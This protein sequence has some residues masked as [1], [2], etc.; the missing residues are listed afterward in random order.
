MYQAL[1][2]V[3]V[4]TAIV[5]LGANITYIIWLTRVN[6]SPESLIFTLRTIKILDDWVANPA[7]VLS[8]LTGLG[9][10]FV[11]GWSLTTPWLL[12]ASILYILV[13]I[14]GL[15]GY[16]RTLNQQIAVVE[17]G[18]AFSVDY[19]AL[20]RRGQVLGLIIIALVVIIV[21]LMVIKPPLWG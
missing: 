11:S 19:A 2:W 20:S 18:G 6:T 17:N 5:A 14:I 7:Y 21:Y 16:S 3:H 10:V 1:K 15:G 13:A 12:L 8:L 9:M 4:L